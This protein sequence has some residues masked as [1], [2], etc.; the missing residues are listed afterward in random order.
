MLEDF[1]RAVQ[2]DRAIDYLKPNTQY[3]PLQGS[4][5]STC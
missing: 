3:S 5:K 4:G 2:V 1:I